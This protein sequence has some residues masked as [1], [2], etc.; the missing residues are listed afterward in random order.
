MNVKLGIIGFGGMGK[1]HAQNAP[2]AGVEITAVCDIDPVKQQEAVGMGYTMY[3]S[4]EELLRDDNVNT[5]IL[6]V[7]NYLHKE[8]CLKA[9]AAGK[10][11]ITE[12]PAAMNVQ[13][14]DEMEAACKKAGVFFTSHQNRRW[15]KDMLIVKKAYDEGLLGNIFTIESK[16]HSGNGYMHEWH[17]YKKYGGGMIYD[18]GVHLI[19]QILFMMPQ[20]KIKS[21]YADI[22]NVLHEEVDDYF[23][24]ILKLDNGVTAHIELSTYILEYQPRWLAAGDKGTLVVKNFGCEGNIYRTG[25]MLEKLPP[26]I[27]ETEA[28]PT[29]QFAP[30]PPG[31]IVTEPLPTVETDWVNFYRNV[32]DVLNGK[33][34]SLIKISEV[35]RVLSVMEAAWK[36]AETNEAILFE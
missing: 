35:R 9:A 17:I 3:P 18:W 32:V 6:T 25:K 12:K 31:G 26:Q 16:L 24:I 4:A 14:L 8:M 7:P 21:V 34:E 27:T 10:H 2:R 11:V 13:E 23:K 36:S 1:W 28:G 30:V 5:V 15:D 19:D 22:K 20:A 33:A 29:R